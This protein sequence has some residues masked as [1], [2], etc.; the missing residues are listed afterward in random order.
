[1]TELSDFWKDAKEEFFGI[2][3]SFCQLLRV[4]HVSYEVIEKASSYFYP[5]DKDTIR[6][7]IT[8]AREKMILPELKNIWIFHYDEQYPKAGRSQM[9][10]RQFE[11]DPSRQSDFDP[12]LSD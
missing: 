10:I 8:D 12:L 1:V 2:F 7:M 11:F 4:D 3:S 5:C 9:C 6:T